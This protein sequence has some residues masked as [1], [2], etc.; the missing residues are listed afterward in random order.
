MPLI[1]MGGPSHTTKIP[2]RYVTYH[3]QAIIICPCTMQICKR[4]IDLPLQSNHSV[5]DL[6]DYPPRLAIVLTPAS[7]KSDTNFTSPEL[8]IKGLCE[9]NCA[10]TLL[11]KSQ[12]MQHPIFILITFCLILQYPQVQ[13]LPPICLSLTSQ[14]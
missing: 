7:G 13:H 9:E 11:C 6:P 4:E 1:M 12:I 3:L 2:P 8:S 10:F 5:H 14:G